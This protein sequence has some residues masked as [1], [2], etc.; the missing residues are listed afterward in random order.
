[1]RATQKFEQVHPLQ[2]AFGSISSGYE[3]CVSEPHTLIDEPGLGNGMPGGPSR[4]SPTQ[5]SLPS[6]YGLRRGLPAQNLY[7]QAGYVRAHIGLDAA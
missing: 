6:P 5:T 4:Q 3:Q 7:Y 2:Y 1:M